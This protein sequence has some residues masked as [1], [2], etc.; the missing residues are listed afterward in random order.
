MTFKEWLDNNI[1]NKDS[2]F[3][4]CTECG[5]EDLN[6]I[7]IF[8]N[9]KELYCAGNNITTLDGLRGMDKIQWIDCS[10]NNISDMSGLCA[11]NLI[12]FY[13]DNPITEYNLYKAVKDLKV[14]NICMDK[15]KQRVFNEK[16]LKLRI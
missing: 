8:K 6:G 9:L 10:S 7:N 2:E 3:I 16:L 5:L 11:E 1:Q 15:L 4:D 13:E 12:L 14:K